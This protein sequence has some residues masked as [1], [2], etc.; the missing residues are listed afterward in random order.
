MTL[1]KIEKTFSFKLEEWEHKSLNNIVIIGAGGNG[2]HII[3]DVAR[4]AASFGRPIQI[5]LV[6]GDVVE[7]KNLIRQHFTKLDLGKNKAEALASRY[8]SAFGIQINF[9]PEYLTQTNSEQVLGSRYNGGNTIFITCTDNLASRKLVENRMNGDIWI[10]LGNEE[11]AG[12]VTISSNAISQYAYYGNP[13]QTGR[14]C[15]PTVFELFPDYERKLKVEKPVASCAE[16]A[17]A[18]PIQAGFVNVMAAAIAKNFLHCVLTGK[19]INNYQVFFTNDNCF[20]HRTITE[21]TYR[22]WATSIPR[23]KCFLETL[24]A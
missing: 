22:R 7:E 2:S 11:S 16:L 1:K 17:A 21:S 4:M 20:E 8:G 10:D 18:S 12:Q 14:F 13:K 3:S 9:V 23:F 24:G 6:D 19:P 15:L 5:T